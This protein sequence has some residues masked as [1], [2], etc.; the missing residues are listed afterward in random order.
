MP[1]FKITQQ[2]KPWNNTVKWLYDKCQEIATYHDYM[3]IE[4][5]DLFVDCLKKSALE[6]GL[7]L[8]RIYIR[9]WDAGGGKKVAGINKVNS[10]DGAALYITMTTNYKPDD[11]ILNQPQTEV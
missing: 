7:S 4:S 5:V 3:G 1:N 6:A 2:R 9:T 8:D 11:C 10:T